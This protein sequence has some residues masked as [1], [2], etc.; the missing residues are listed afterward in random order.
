[1]PVMY[2]LPISVREVN[3]AGIRILNYIIKDEFAGMPTKNK[4]RQ[5]INTTSL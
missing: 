5:Y 4:E 3:K 1:M 2:E